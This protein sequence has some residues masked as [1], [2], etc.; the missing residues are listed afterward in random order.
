[1]LMRPF[2]FRLAACCLIL[3]SIDFHSPALGDEA[4]LFNQLGMET[5][6][7]LTG[8][9]IGIT[10]TPEGI[11]LRAALQDLE[12]EATEQ[13]L[14]IKSTEGTG[15]TGSQSAGSGGD[16]DVERFRVMATGIGRSMTD[17]EGQPDSFIALADKGPVGVTDGNLT[18]TRAGVIEEYSVDG[19][20]VRQDFLVSEC[21]PGFGKLNLRLSVDGARVEMADYG[22]KLTFHDSAQ[23]EIAYSRLKVTDAVGK[24][25]S[26]RMEPQGNQI[27]VLVEDSNAVYPLRIDPTFSDADWM[28]V[29]TGFPE[30]TGIY[31]MATD[32]SGSLYIGGSF[33]QVG[34]VP[35]NNIAKWN[36]SEWSALGQGLN[37][38][39]ARLT[40]SGGD[41]YAGGTFT[42]AGGLTVN[43]IA[44]W[45]GSEWSALGSGL[46]PAASSGGIVVASPVYG[47]AVMGAYVY[48]GGYFSVKSNGIPNLAK[49]DGARWSRVGDGV[50][51]NDLIMALA[52]NG[53]DLYVAGSFSQMNGVS[54]KKIAKWNGSKWSALGTGL[55]T[56]GLVYSMTAT[57]S[58]LY[59]GGNFDKAGGVTVNGV[60]KWNGSVWSALGTPPGFSDFFNNVASEMA[61]SGDNLYVG[62]TFSMVGGAAAQNIAKWDGDS[63]SALGSGVDGTVYSLLVSGGDLHVGGR[64]TKAGG[65]VSPFVAV[66]KS[67]RPIST[68]AAVTGVT[69]SAATLNGIV[70]PNGTSTTARFEYGLTVEYGRNAEVAL[71]PPGG[72]ENQSI[73][74]N[75]TG[76]TA[77]TVYHYRLTAAN[78]NGVTVTEDAT[79]T[80][81]GLAAPARTLFDNAMTAA[82]LNGGNSTPMAVPQ[83][84]GVSNLLK[85]AFGMSLSGS[86]ARTLTPST[87]IAGLP[88]I[89]VRFAGTAGFLR[90][91]FV[92]GIGNGLEYNPQKSVDLTTDSWRSF[93]SS[94]VIST[95]DNKRERVIY[96]EP[97]D[98]AMTPRMSARVSVT[99]PD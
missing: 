79:F 76:L 56:A 63:W 84:D 41:I 98:P 16:R 25:F 88:S 51:P 60:A 85:Y 89:S 2:F 59:I 24:E 34:G 43:R 99:L 92:R 38:T 26:A 90:C 48:V 18:W 23:R 44:K 28:S 6:R 14:W 37:N 97:F 20:G 94:A 75:L 39:V 4:I 83:G 57:G 67:P 77:G 27:Q 95:I 68:V 58:N 74:V 91:E 11:Q 31:D 40:A 78:V 50:E 66:L 15:K 32:S 21:P 19:D 86:D 13:G 35:A 87:G 82:G 17:H 12:A 49:W 81:S 71:I 61:V 80:T 22:V 96:E 53:S 65:K 5:S 72:D 29:N 3:F 9:E 33:T 46:N 42:M 73:S 70:N 52:Q 64:F 8:D 7:R 47:I 93:T 36:G 69:A 30:N 10:L 1:M 62:G 55:G 54:A 45:N